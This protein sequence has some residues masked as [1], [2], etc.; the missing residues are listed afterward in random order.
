MFVNTQLGEGRSV[1][2]DQAHTWLG[3]SGMI[4]HFPLPLDVNTKTF[5]QE[6]ADVSHTLGMGY[7][8][9]RK[10]GINTKYLCFSSILHIQFHHGS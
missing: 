7:I 5:L 3:L 9:W 4:E 8:C 10:K 6:K 2:A 1:V